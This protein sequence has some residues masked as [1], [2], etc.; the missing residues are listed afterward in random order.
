VYEPDRSTEEP[1]PQKI[2][3]PP[4]SSLQTESAQLLSLH[5]QAAV[6]PQKPS[7]LVRL[8]SN[9]KELRDH[10]KKAVELLDKMTETG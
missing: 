3:K 9:L 7:L 6:D 2:S 4:P 1:P 8:D 5:Y 10:L